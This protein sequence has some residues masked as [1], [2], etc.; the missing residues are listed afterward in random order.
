MKEELD[1]ITE[2]KLEVIATKIADK[3]K[4]QKA[5]YLNSND[6]LNNTSF[7]PFIPMKYDINLK[8][9]DILLVEKYNGIVPALFIDPFFIDLLKLY[10][11][12]LGKDECNTI[13]ISRD[14]YINKILASN[15][16]SADT[17]VIKLTKCPS[18]YIRK[19][20]NCIC[21]ALPLYLTFK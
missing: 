1:Y 17:K 13:E 2:S 5:G 6:L 18:E 8:I 20:I 16:E 21:D 19:A 10:Y 9:D 12:L 14:E 7:A 4:F 15:P 3:L 11:K